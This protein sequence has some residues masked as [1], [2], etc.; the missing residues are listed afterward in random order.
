MTSCFT[1]ATRRSDDTDTGARRGPRFCSLNAAVGTRQQL[2]STPA[3]SFPRLPLRGR[4]YL[5]CFEGM[6]AEEH[7][8]DLS[9]LS[10]LLCLD[11]RYRRHGLP[12]NEIDRMN[13]PT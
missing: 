12:A 9:G 13:T 6:E 7:L 4:G 2:G 1:N 10:R 3:R 11:A 8:V 5:L